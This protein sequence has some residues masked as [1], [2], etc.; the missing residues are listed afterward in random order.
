MSPRFS[1]RLL[2]G[3]SDERL[4]NL[5]RAGHERAFEALVQRYRRPLLRFCRR[6]SRSG[7][8]GTASPAPDG[9]AEERR[10]DGAAQRRG[11]RRRWRDGVVQNDRTV[12]T[13]RRVGAASAPA[14][15]QRASA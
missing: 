6:E 15:A 7:A 13:L 4:L 8:A 12:E 11:R 9:T 1:L 14:A 10:T 3:Q 5:A 2:S